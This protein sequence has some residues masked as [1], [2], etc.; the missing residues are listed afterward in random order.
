MN[1]YVYLIEKRTDLSDAQKYYIGVRSCDSL[2]C[3]DKYMGSSDY[4]T[5]IIKKEGKDNFNKIILKRFETREEA[6]NYEI[7]L[8]A[9]FDVVNNPLFFNRANQTSSRFGA[10]SKENNPFFGKTHPDEWK[11][12]KSLQMRGNK[13]ASG[14][15]HTEEARKIIKEKRAKQVF[16]PESL[17]K[18]KGR[19]PW[20][21]GKIGLYKH[22]EEWKANLSKRNKGKK[23]ALGNKLTD[24][25]KQKMSDFFKG[26]VW[27]N[28]GIKNY[29]IRPEF[30]EEKLK[31]GLIKGTL[32]IKK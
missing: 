9:L 6:F 11:K 1:H 23:F 8:H 26:I 10:G 30:V 17:A 3:E 32:K 19:T 18:L 15:K 27:M 25:Q 31:M 28:D 14:Y 24:A 20:N 16:T 5:K 2:I 7:E 21:K 29:R 12:Q 22:T 4:L 13:N